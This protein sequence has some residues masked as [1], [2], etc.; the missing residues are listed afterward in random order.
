LDKNLLATILTRIDKLEQDIIADLEELLHD[1]SYSE[2]SEI[3][4]KIADRLAKKAQLI[5]RFTP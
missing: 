5:R 1:C 4:E 3:K 2:K